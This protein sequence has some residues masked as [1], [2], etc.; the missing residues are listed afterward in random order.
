MGDD[1]DRT[2]GGSELMTIISLL[3]LFDTAGGA[4]G[5]RGKS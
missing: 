2:V 4:D 3:K 1:D 5:G